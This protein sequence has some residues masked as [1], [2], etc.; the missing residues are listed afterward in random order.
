MIFMLRLDR[1]QD[2]SP[3][4]T[5]SFIKEFSPASTAKILKF[6]ITSGFNEYVSIHE[7][8]VTD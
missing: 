1:D 5:Q 2:E 3:N 7:L 4:T 6:I 8:S